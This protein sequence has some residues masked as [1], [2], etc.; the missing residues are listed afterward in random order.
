MEER[1]ITDTYVKETLIGIAAASFSI[2]VIVALME[3]GGRAAFSNSIT[4]LL[5]G[6]IAPFIFLLDAPWLIILYLLTG[7][8]LYFQYRR[9]PPR[10]MRYIVGAEVIVWQLI[11][12]WLITA[13][14]TIH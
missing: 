4:L 6:Y 8:A 7:A 11:G 12:I 2:V 14:I 5:Y 3:G 13:F 9:V 1:T 10:F